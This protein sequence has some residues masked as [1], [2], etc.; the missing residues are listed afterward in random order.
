MLCPF[1]RK[2][3]NFAH[4]C[5]LESPSLILS[6]LLAPVRALRKLVLRYLTLPRPSFLAVKL[7]HGT[8]NPQTALYNFERKGLQPWYVRP[9]FWSKWGPGALFV[10]IMG[11]R[12]PGSRGDRYL[13]QG[14]DLMTIGPEPQEGKGLEEMGLDMEV[15]R[16]RGIATCPF[17]QA[18]SGSF[19]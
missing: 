15:I 9:T 1:H 2:L 5:S 18:K 10:R 8:P 11:G 14:Y 19:A 16:S 12:I 13:P 3:L 17:S 6:F 4:D 7:V